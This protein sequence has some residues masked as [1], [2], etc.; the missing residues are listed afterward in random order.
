MRQWILALC[1]ISA[2]GDDG[3]GGTQDSGNGSDTGGAK[4]VPGKMS[5]VLGGTGDGANAQA[6]APSGSLT[7]NDEYI[8]SPRKAKI[9]F[10]SMAFRKQDG[11]KLGDGDI[12]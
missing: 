7:P 2:C 4:T 10:V 3:G 12:M 1:V 5:F 8:V 11:N 6:S 9:T